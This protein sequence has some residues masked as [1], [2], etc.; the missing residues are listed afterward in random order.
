[1]TLV[2]SVEFVICL[3]LGFGPIPF[4]DA[5]KLDAAVQKIKTLSAL[6]QKSPQPI[7]NIPETDCLQAAGSAIT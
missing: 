1:M 6:Q 3:L 7:G 4:P 2:K 5:E